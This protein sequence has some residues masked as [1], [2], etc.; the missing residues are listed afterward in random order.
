MTLL[1]EQLKKHEGFRAQVYQCTA[2]HNTVGY[3]YNLDANPLKL[4]PFEISEI[5]KNGIK[6][7][8][9][10]Y[11]LLRMISRIEEKLDE[12]NWFQSLDEARRSVLINM[13]YNLGIAGVLK[14]KSMIEEIKRQNWQKAAE[15]MIDS[16]WAKQVGN[17][18]RELSK[19][20]LSGKFE[21]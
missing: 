9:A 8:T 20:M 16:A 18:A 10:N 15:Q 13:A 21:E 4:T 17:R 11:L 14:F 5:K 6:E 7:A 2:G 19:Q 1:L 12:L 3:G